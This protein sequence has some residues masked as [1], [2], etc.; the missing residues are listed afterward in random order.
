MQ[1]VD[2]IIKYIGIRKTNKLEYEQTNSKEQTPSWEA[3]SALA[4]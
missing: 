3:T 4:T 1:T 2:D